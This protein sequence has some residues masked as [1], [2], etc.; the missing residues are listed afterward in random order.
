MVDSGEFCLGGDNSDQGPVGLY[1]SVPPNQWP[2]IRWMLKPSVQV[3]LG[4]H[5]WWVEFL[6][7]L[8]RAGRFEM[9]CRTAASYVPEI[10][11]LKSG[12]LVEGG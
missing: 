2:A 12:E 3:I 1:L 10:Y 4:Q 11:S 9:S 5:L 6:V 7:A 8:H